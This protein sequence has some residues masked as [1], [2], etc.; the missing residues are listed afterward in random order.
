MGFLERVGIVLYPNVKCEL[1]FFQGFIKVQFSKSVPMPS[2]LLFAK[3]GED[4]WFC[5][6]I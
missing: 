2:V 3:W 4:T 1:V 6:L 5:T